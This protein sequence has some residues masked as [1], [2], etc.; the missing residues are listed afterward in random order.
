MSLGSKI[1]KGV[2]IVL[3]DIINVGE[4]GSAISL[5]GDNPCI[6]GAGFGPAEFHRV[7]IECANDGSGRCGAGNACGEAHNVAGGAGSAAAVTF[8]AN[9]ILGL[10][11]KGGDGIFVTGDTI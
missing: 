10:G 3:G 8:H 5:V 7:G 11:I 4:V 2:G 9:H 1:T 6:S